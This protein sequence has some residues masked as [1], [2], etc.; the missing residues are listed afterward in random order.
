MKTDDLE[1]RMRAGECY[2]SLRVPPG[3]FAVIRVDGRSFSR[4][5]ERLVEKP[6]DRT[7][8]EWMVKAAEGLLSTLHATYA[9]TESDEISVLLPR[10]TELFDRE[11]EKLV[12]VSAARAS[13]VVSLHCGEAVEFD[14]RLWVGSRAPDV[15]DY[16]RWR[17]AD[18][19]RCALNGW[20][21]WTL[22]KAG[23]SVR[24]ATRSLEG[25]TVS[26]KNEILFSNGI[27]FNEVPLWQR[28]GTG[29]Y[30]EQFEKEGF[31][32]KTKKAVKAVRRRL[33]VNE[34]LPMKERYG[35]FI[36]A[37]LGEPAESPR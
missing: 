17:Q 24:E 23:K 34:A 37:L 30:W 32:P 26:M 16:F 15:I 29:I 9:Y 19:T 36:E 28:R 12:S 20:C 1:V 14:A 22:R 11:V 5:T 25:A 21:Y 8:H 13:S 7:F 2:H 33:T 35:E 6:F 31:N 18:A 4:L 10:E 3:A 27:N